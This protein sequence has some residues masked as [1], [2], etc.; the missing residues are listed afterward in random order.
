MPSSQR[1]TLRFAVGS[2][3]EYRSAVWGLRVQ[4]N[5]V[6]LSARHLD[7]LMKV[8]MHRSGIWRLAWTEQSGIKVT[9]SPDRVALRWQRPSEFRPGWT[10]GLAVVVPHS[11]IQRPFRHDSAEDLSK[12]LWV[13]TPA[14]GN[15][16]RL[17]VLFVKPSA[18]P[19]S[20]QEVILPDDRQLG[21]LDLR[22]GDRVAL[23]QR[24][25]AMVEKENLFVIPFVADMRINYDSAVPEVTGASVF[26]GGTDDAGYPY[27][28]DLA[29]GW[30]NVGGPETPPPA[31]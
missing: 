28:L 18:P 9:G 1:K 26:S 15:Q 22:N 25:I 16:H 14:P 23:L 31:A 8:S 27:L 10:Q 29:L 2:P 5:D 7:G 12:V 11:G 13:P 4:G 6:Y 17:T 30:E 21:T 20:W 24:E 19:D 3:D